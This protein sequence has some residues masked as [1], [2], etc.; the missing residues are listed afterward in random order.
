V[1]PK[2]FIGERRALQ[3]KRLSMFT[4]RPVEDI[5]YELDL[6]DT[7]YFSHFFKARLGAL[8]GK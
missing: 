2:E 7:A 8:P 3:A 6:K 4:V 5:A 1:S